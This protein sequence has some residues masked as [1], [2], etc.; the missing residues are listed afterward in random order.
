VAAAVVA[1]LVVWTVAVRVYDVEIVVNAGRP[2]PVGPA[3]IG[4]GAGAAGLCGWALLSALERV[5]AYAAVIWTAVALPILILSLAAPLNA[6]TVPAT[7]SAARD[8]TTRCV[9]PD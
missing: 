1:A 7:L 6:T 2:R 4:A 8:V 5:T 3:E 9:R